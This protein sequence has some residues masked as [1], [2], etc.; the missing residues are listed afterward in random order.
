MGAEHRAAPKGTSSQYCVYDR[1]STPWKQRQEESHSTTLQQK[2]RERHHNNA[3]KENQRQNQ[4]EITINYCGYWY[5][6]CI[7]GGGAAVK[8]LHDDIHQD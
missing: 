5:F 8:K 1:I 4:K 6:E 7:R 3:I 2:Q